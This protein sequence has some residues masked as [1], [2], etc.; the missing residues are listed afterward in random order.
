[1][2]KII[3]VVVLFF[4][5]ACGNHNQSLHDLVQKNWHYVS[6]TDGAGNDFKKVSSSDIMTLDAGNFRYDL[7]QENIHASGTWKLQD[8]TLVFNYSPDS[9]GK[10][11]VRNFKITDCSDTRLVFTENGITFTYS[12]GN[13]R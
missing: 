5:A 12:D 3:P 2:R 4:L 11:K 1:M 13:T 8:S 10:S 6:V 7:E 9:T